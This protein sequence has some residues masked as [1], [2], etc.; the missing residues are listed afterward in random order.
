MYITVVHEITD[1]STFWGAAQEA[2]TQPMPEG[3]SL[4]GVLPSTNGSHAVCLWEA[5]SVD[6]VREMVESLVGQV[7]KNDYHEVDSANARGLPA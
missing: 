5:P 2:I 7:S 4:H 1:P 3:V 6:A